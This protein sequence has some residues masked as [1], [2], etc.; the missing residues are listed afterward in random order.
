MLLRP[1]TIENLS[2]RHMASLAELTG[3]YGE[4][5]THELLRAWFGSRPGWTSVHGP[6]GSSG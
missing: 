3:C 5:W 4:R 2:R 1:F 6:P